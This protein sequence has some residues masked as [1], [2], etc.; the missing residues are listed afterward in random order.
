MPKFFNP[1]TISKAFDS[2]RY[3]GINRR[4]LAKKVGGDAAYNQLNYR[5]RSTEPIPADFM[6]PYFDL[7]PELES[8]SKA[9]EKAGDSLIEPNEQD[10][11]SE[12]AVLR[13]KVRALESS[14]SDSMARESRLLNVIEKMAG[15]EN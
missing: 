3:S 12:V 8:V 13:E 15:G 1:K 7:A 9:I 11:Q 10:V 14:L 6:R 2:L 5:L 4:T